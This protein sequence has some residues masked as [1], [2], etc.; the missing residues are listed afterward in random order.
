MKIIKNHLCL[1]FLG[2]SI[3]FTTTSSAQ[4]RSSLTQ[5]V[6][7]VKSNQVS[8]AQLQVIMQRAIEA[9]LTPDQIESLA[10]SRGMSEDEIEKFKL[11]AERLY[12]NKTME[13]GDGLRINTRPSVDYPDSFDERFF[14]I[15][16][17]KNEPN[18]GFSLFRNS[19][20]TFEPSF[21]IATPKNYLIG[22]GDLLNIDVWGASQHSYQEV[23]SNEGNIIISNIG[24]IDLSGLSIEEADQKLKTILSKIYSGIKDGN[25]FIKV[26]LG[27]V[28]NIQINIVGE[29][30]LPGTYN[31]SSLAT[32]FNAM[33]VAGGP[34]EN[35]SL[36]D[37]QI[38]RDNK[39][40]AIVDFYEYLLKGRQTNNKR[41]QDQDIIF[42][43]PYSNRVSIKGKVKREKQ[44]DIKLSESLE[45]LIY[46]AGGFTGNA[47]TE[48]IKIFR[49]TGKEYRVLD[50]AATYLDAINLQNGDE[51]MIDSVL[52]RFENRVFITGAV[53]RPGIFA[54]DSI[55]TLKQL[56]KKAD[57]LREDVFKNRISIFRLREDLSREHIAIDLNELLNS[58]LDFTLQREDSIIISSIYDL[59]ETRTIRIEGEVKYPGVYPYSENIKVEDLIIQAGGLLE[60]ASTANVEI[61]RRINNG[62]SL[63]TENKL[64]DIIKFQ[65]DKSLGLDKSAST[66]I[67]KPFDQVFIRKSPAYI[68]Q[69]IVSIEGEVNFPGKYTITSRTERI[70]DLIK[71]AGNITTE[72]Y[73]KGAS[74]IRKQTSDKVLTNRAISN[75]AREKE[76][77]NKVI[78]SQDKFDVIGVDLADILKNPGGINDLYLQEGDSIRILKHS[79]TI[80][81]SGSVYNPNVIPYQKEFNLKDYIY[82]AGGFTKGSK[83]GHIYVVY[84]NGSVKKTKRTLFFRNYPQIEPGAE[85]IIPNKGEKRRMSMAETI[86]IS[87]AAASMALLLV[88]LINA[89]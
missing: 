86:G 3:L 4:T 71:R 63:A 53:F 20:L 16:E 76:S 85:I 27:A 55:S 24:P 14:F 66:F 17:I 1:L 82:N 35:G 10:R 48:R 84:A 21:N 57:G 47:Y 2:L 56:I 12:D 41:L 52:N 45:D 77:S 15:Q 13:N 78:I 23:V 22:P 8:D 49:K 46:F 25:T 42:V 88:T 51:I 50:I 83:P 30:L 79:Q 33:Y 65:I 70:S 40:V 28:R 59:R 18:F 29:V 32:V 11:R 68:P 74:L 60:T 6:S 34:S 38:I 43:S 80:K 5:N 89:L 62:A 67:L 9:G 58:N 36:R 37:V 39:V 81:V 31:L 26:T 54:I 75:I 7:K 87:S 64:A 61:A 73:L 44:F 19:D 72:A 69:M